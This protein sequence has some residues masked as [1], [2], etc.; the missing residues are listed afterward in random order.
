MASITRDIFKAYDIRGIVGKTL[1]DD[2]AYFIGRAI[3]AKA[4]EKGIA[5]IAIGRDGRLSGP[6]LMEHIQRGLTDSGIGVLNVG[7]VTT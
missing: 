3:A 4:A 7:M 5:R 6:E 1:T 2:A